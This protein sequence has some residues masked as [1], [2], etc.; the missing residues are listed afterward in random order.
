MSQGSLDKCNIFVK[1]L[2][3]ELTNDEFHLLFKSYGTIVSSKIMID[4]STGNSLGY[5]FVRFSEQESAERA[6]SEM[7]GQHIAN[8]RLLCKLAN[9]SPS[10][11]ASEP[12]TS[13]L[14]SQEPSDNLYIKPLLSSTTEEDL[15][16]LFAGFGEISDCKV[17][18]DRHT[19]V[20]RQIGFVRFVQSDSA[21]KA[22]N[23]MNGYQLQPNAP[24]LLVKYADTKEQKDARKAMRYTQMNK[25]GGGMNVDPHGGDL[26]F[27][28]PI[29]IPLS[30]SPQSYPMYYAGSPTPMGPPLTF[31]SP[32]GFA[33]PYGYPQGYY[34]QNPE[35]HGYNSPP[36]HYPTM[37][38]DPNHQMGGSP[39]SVPIGGYAYE[40]EGG[41]MRVPV[42]MTS[43]S[44][45][46][47]QQGVPVG[48][49]DGGNF[50]RPP[51]MGGGSPSHRLSAG[52]RSS[53]PRTTQSVNMGMGMAPMH[54]QYYAP[55]H[56]L[57]KRPQEGVGGSVGPAGNANGAMKM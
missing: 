33:S 19:G 54:P 15:R 44:G 23:A 57:G 43:A 6:I 12:K 41:I 48:V 56:H 37:A 21:A 32:Y 24:P 55:P 30:S 20:S 50:N 45:A 22:L 1:F 25:F 9:Q 49:S 51:H 31:G 7:N 18:V 42:P 47:N 3:P 46:V 14:H 40:E 5:G 10:T 52:R 28:N 39:H 53:L 26:K 2:P 29:G 36:L 16:A 27:S 11:F 38:Y 34:V 4:Q 17:M 8:K 13:V 35:I